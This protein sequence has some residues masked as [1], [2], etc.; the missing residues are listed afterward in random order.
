MAGTTARTVAS[1]CGVNRKTA[2]YFFVRLR[3][4]IALEL[5]AE[6]EA[7]FDGEIEVDGSCFGGKRKGVRGRAT[8]G[9][10]PASRTQWPVPSAGRRPAGAGKDPA[11]S[12]HGDGAQGRIRTTDTVI[13]SHVLYQLSYLGAHRVGR[14]I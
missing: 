6:S 9:K 7:M 4:V 12:A 10:G 13:F 11:K 14:R 3:E 5:E 8:A 2:A 1:L